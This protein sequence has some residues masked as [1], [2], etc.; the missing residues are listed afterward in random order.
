MLLKKRICKKKYGET[1]PIFTTAYDWFVSQAE[2][3]VPKHQGA[4]YPYWAFK[5]LHSVDKSSENSILK[6]RCR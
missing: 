4:E 6:L 2:K 5:D 1:S 3:Y